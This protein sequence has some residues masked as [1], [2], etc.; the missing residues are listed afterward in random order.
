MT[1]FGAVR[2]CGDGS[3]GQF[4][5]VYSLTGAY[6]LLHRLGFSWLMPRPRHAKA[7]KEVQD[8][9]KKKRPRKSK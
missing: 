4:G 6:D 7:S 3:R 1:G 8:E 5:V 9:F 2:I